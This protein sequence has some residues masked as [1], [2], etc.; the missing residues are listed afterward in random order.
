MN[1]LTVDVLS[2]NTKKKSKLH[3]N[4]CSLRVET[5]QNEPIEFLK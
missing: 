5:L 3:P 1:A 4:G 2:Q